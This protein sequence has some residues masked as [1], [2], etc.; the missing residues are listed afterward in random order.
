MRRQLR[1]LQSNG[2]VECQLRMIGGTYIKPTASLGVKWAY[3][4]GGEDDKEGKGARG[5][6][7]RRK[8]GVGVQSVFDEM[9]GQLPAPLLHQSIKF[10]FALI[11]ISQLNY[12]M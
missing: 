8:M 12:F 3:R 10:E 5:A 2:S 6:G 7:R 11:I 1:R 4:R 9:S